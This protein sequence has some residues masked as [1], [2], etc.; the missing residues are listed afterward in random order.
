MVKKSAIIVLPILN[1]AF[2][3]LKQCTS[4]GF[5]FGKKDGRPSN[6]KAS[7]GYSVGTSGTKASDGYSVS[8]SGGR[9]SGTK[10]SDGYSVGTSGGRPSGTKASDGYYNNYNI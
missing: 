8:T 1:Y 6:T 3:N 2:N 10:A 5:M 4:C 7:D 9:P